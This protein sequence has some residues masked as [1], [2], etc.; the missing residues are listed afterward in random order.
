[1]PLYVEVA[2]NVNQVSGAYD[3]HLPPELEQAVQPGHLVVVPFGHQTVQGVVLRRV[4]I[5]SFPQTR[6]VLALLDEQVVVTPHQI[7]LAR[8]LAEENLAPLAAF[9]ALMLPAGMSRQSDTLYGLKPD[10]DTRGLNQVQTRLVK[11]L[12]ERG[13]LRGR[14]VDRSLERVKWRPQADNLE[15]RGVIF[16][17]PVLPEPEVQPKRVNQ[18]HLL[19][20]AEQIQA[21]WANLGKSGSA[22]RQRREAV[23]QFLLAEPGPVNV[24]WVYAHSGANLADLRR[25]EALGLVALEQTEA[26]RDP[27][28]GIA[29]GLISPGLALAKPPTLTPDQVSALGVISQAL[30]RALNPTQPAP[31]SP[32]LLH[33]VTGSG[34]T[35]IYLQAA[36]QTVQA[37]R[38]AVILVPEIALT[39]QTVR[40]FLVRFPGRVGLVHS[41]LSVGERY[42]TWRRV[43]SGQLDI[44]VGPR[45]ALFMPVPRLGL[46]VV[47][48]CHDHSYYQSDFSPTYHARSA[49]LAYAE[50]AGALCILGSA[51]PSIE[52]RFQAEQ[53]RWTWLSLPNRILAHKEQTRQYLENHP[54]QAQSADARAA[55]YAGDA[56]LTNL[57]EIRMVDMR[58]ELKAGN[59][60]IFS[61]ALQLA[62]EETL[63]R[64][65]QA[66]I[67]LNR[68]GSATY[69]FCRDCGHALGCPRCALVSLTL[70][71]NVAGGGEERLVCHHCGYQRSMPKKCPACGS[72]R[73]REFGTGTE[74]VEAE[75]QLAFPGVRTLRWD[76]QTTRTKGSHE[77]ILDQFVNQRADVLVGTQMLA[78]GLDLP[79]VT[80][81]GVV[82]ADVGLHLPDFRA[83]ERVFQVLSQVSGRAGRSPLGGQVILQTFEPE[84]Y[85][86]QAAARHDYDGFYQRELAYRKEMGYPPFSRL[87]RLEYRH[88]DPE[89]AAREAQAL[90]DQLRPWTQ[91]AGHSQTELI[92]PA[93]CFF[94]KLD[95][96]YR[97]HIILRGPDPAALLR[98][99]NLTGRIL[100]TWR[101]EVEPQSLL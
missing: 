5:P 24:A 57:P 48:E 98:T 94:S 10:A 88:T 96:T 58:Q 39:P 23:I 16:K 13:P 30:S 95:N 46:V 3:Y 19:A 21:A 35:E 27:L 72:Q 38:Q 43:R 92:G 25:L 63:S 90:A 89:H 100:A 61:R 41:G 62:L 64:H 78:K 2:V 22:A 79:L 74:K 87:V 26:I 70:H 18:V 4:D 33:G 15:R 20:A 82:L 84:N 66:I 7:Q 34:K 45:S 97:W 80:L 93:P 6:A 68:R 1:M 83:G 99:A 71:R 91:S 9:I 101:V 40:R 42:D 32:I 17:Q 36:A 44:V 37:G 51:T 53:K 11:L 55:S 59:R 69:V 76:W 31:V 14:Q 28:E 47:D 75:I 73:I 67:F 49:A 86:L 77:V 65:Q 29:P 54:E 81:V 8:V 50:L 56:R 12:V 60:S 85:V 52:D